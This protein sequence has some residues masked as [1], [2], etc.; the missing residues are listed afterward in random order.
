[1]MLALFNTLKT[2]PDFFFQD[3]LEFDSYQSKDKLFADIAKLS[4]A[5]CQLVRGLVDNL[6]AQG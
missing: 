3:E 5:Q 4:P 6:L 2:P 1:M